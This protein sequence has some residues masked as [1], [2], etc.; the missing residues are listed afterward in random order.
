VNVSTVC[1]G[2]CVGLEE[3]AEGI[4]DVDFRTRRLGRLDERHKRTQDEYGRL[5]RR[6]V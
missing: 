3:I 4:W 1:A 2:E 6:D 5:Y